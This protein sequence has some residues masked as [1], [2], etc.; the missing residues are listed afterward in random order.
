MLEKMKRKVF[1]FQMC[2]SCGF[3]PKSAMAPQRKEKEHFNSLE[4]SL[5]TLHYIC[6][7]RLVF[8]FS[9]SETSH[10]YHSL[11]VSSPY[12]GSLPFPSCLLRNSQTAFKKDFHK[13][14]LLQIPPPTPDLPPGPPRSLARSLAHSLSERHLSLSEQ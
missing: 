7:Y 10:P 1:F 9:S 4:T 11:S 2:T 3:G 5:F 6:T 8:F 13:R 12:T 14:P